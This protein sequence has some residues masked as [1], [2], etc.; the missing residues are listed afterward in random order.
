MT[1]VLLILAATAVLAFA[2][3]SLG[4]AA[5][6]I[7]FLWGQGVTPEMVAPILAAFT[8]ETGIPV[9]YIDGDEFKLQVMVVAGQP[10]D[11]FGLASPS[12]S[13]PFWLGGA[14]LELTP[15]MERDGYLEDLFYP[16]IIAFFRHFGGGKLYALPLS[17]TLHLTTYNQELFDRYGVAYPTSGMTLTEILNLARRM[18][19]GEPGEHTIGY[20]ISAGYMT[21]QVGS[22]AATIGLYFYDE[23]ATKAALNDPRWADFLGLLDEH[24]NDFNSLCDYSS[25]DA[26]LYAQGRGAMYRT[27]TV[28]IQNWR[29][30]HPFAWDAV[31][32]PALDEAGG[33]I[34]T[35][36][37]Q[38]LIAISS[39]SQRVE[40]AWQLVKFLTGPRGQI[41]LAEYA[42]LLPARRGSEYVQ[43]FMKPDQ[44]P[45]NLDWIYPV[46]Y[47]WPVDRKVPPNERFIRK[48]VLLPLFW[49][50]MDGKR[51]VQE[52]LTLANE[53][54]QAALDEGRS[55]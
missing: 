54:V 20:C 27:P 53:R 28:F 1:R 5:E 44:P 40:E 35:T 23:T 10:P 46:G 38:R 21:E 52:F 8:E 11:A 16:N 19:R 9:E 18:T 31:S 34:P 43:A 45:Y 3:W 2:P 49:D 22:F 17:Y 15:L 47:S 37:E 4:S 12:E 26:A 33:I 25:G 39:S 24:W 36:A 14:A 13:L 7:S 29:D 42:G 51:S 48:D 32:D 30:S 6:R 55:E 50:L 41:L